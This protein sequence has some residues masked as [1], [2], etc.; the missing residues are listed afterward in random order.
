MRLSSITI[1]D[2]AAF[3]GT[4][5]FP[6]HAV[7]LIQGDHG[8]GKSSLQDIMAYAFGRRPLADPGHRAISHDPSMI[9]GICERGEAIIIF[10]EGMQYRLLVTA[11]QTTRQIKMTG[12]KR[13]DTAT[14]DFI[15][16][17]VNALS[18]GPFSY[19]DLT[20]K[21]RIEALL[22]ASPIIVT[23]EEIRAAIGDAGIVPNMQ[24][25]LESINAYHRELYDLRRD[26]N[27]AADTQEKH[28]AELQRDL[29]APVEGGNW[30]A[31]VVLLRSEKKIIEQGESNDIK[32]IG[33]ALD[34][35]KQSNQKEHCVR[36]EG[37][38]QDINAKI[39]AL[40]EDRRNRLQ[41][42]AS[43][44]NAADEVARAKANTDSQAILA[45]NKPE[46]DRLTS[47]I[48]TAEER[49]RMD[50]LIEGKRQAAESALTNAALRRENSKRMSA[51][52]DRLT[53]LKEEVGGRLKVTGVA[54]ASPKDGQP[55][56]V[57]REENGA[58]VPF[59]RWNEASK[60]MFCLRMAVLFH[61]KCGVVFVD[62][63]GHFTEERKKALIKT[64]RKY[65]AEENMQFILGEATGGALAV[66]EA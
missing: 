22:K 24:P 48:A 56:D 31:E 27:V 10:D 40:E 28:A 36:T 14:P 63:I 30:S 47:S 54:I 55:V 2:L 15:D 60:D 6:L 11:D 19:K 9:H 58:L 52:M 1:T 42:S 26:E 5:T 25:S 35:A 29:P 23:T 8:V 33:R 59:S 39:A 57:C 38:N 13:W 17:L 34:A 12:G 7:S 50:T 44:R 41:S 43:D 49:A 4:V 3:A 51:A 18:Y 20:E 32:G 16:S 53:A 64:C 62:E 65:A 46:H 37:I 61:G 66:V 21:Q 45:R